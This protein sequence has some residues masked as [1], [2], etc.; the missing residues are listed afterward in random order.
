MKTL[1]L[2]S[3]P[4]SALIL[5]ISLIAGSVHAG[6]DS[7]D[8][9][10]LI[11]RHSTLNAGTTNPRIA[12][13]QSKPHG[14]SY[15]ERAATWWKWAL[16]TP[17]SANPLID[18]T[19]ANCDVNQ[20]DHVWFLA[21]SFS[22]E[23]VTR[24]CTVPRGVALFFPLIN[25]FYG[26]FLTDPPEQRTEAFIRSQ[27]TCI[28]DASFSLVEIDGVAVINPR[29]YLEKSVIFDVFLPED[30][31][32]GATPAEIPDLT[33]SPSVDEGFYLFVR[34]LTPGSHTIRWRASS[35][36]CGFSED[37]TYHLTVN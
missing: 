28:E 30:N 14:N 34:P 10:R 27:V 9:D 20:T 21:G 18:T 26:A 11:K 15:S 12:P 3:R 4:I 5:F 8:M 32:F 29:Q 19:G 31:I 23:P 37:I 22:S 24:Q 17:A 6:L 2:R 13:I 35:A 25:L 7:R 16:E 1:Q 33:L 36:A